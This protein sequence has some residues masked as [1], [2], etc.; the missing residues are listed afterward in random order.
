MDTRA[1]STDKRVMIYPIVADDGVQTMNC[2]NSI[3]WG[4]RFNEDGSMILSVGDDGSIQLYLRQERVS[5]VC[6]NCS[7][8]GMGN[9]LCPAS[10]STRQ[11]TV[12]VWIQKENEV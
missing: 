6:Y 3:V 7:P 9:I 8:P 5:F 1:S 10:Q 12:P 11:D 4:V 2:H